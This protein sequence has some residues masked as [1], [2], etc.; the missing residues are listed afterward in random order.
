MNSNF[1]FWE[2]KDAEYFVK[3]T[4]AVHTLLNWEGRPRRVS[5]NAVIQFSGVH[6][7]KRANA[8]KTI[9]KTMAYLEGNIETATSWQKRKIV[10]AI[11][12]LI[13]QDESVIPNKIQTIASISAAEFK[14]LRSFVIE[15]TEK[16]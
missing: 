1:A 15:Q 11:G 13:K 16:D 14:K 2:E 10:W 12:E 4:Y 5:M 6:Q 8:E 9:P 3:V 7:M